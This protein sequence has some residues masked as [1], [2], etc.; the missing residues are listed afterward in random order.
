MSRRE[1]AAIEP[2]QQNTRVLKRIDLKVGATDRGEL[3]G[4]STTAAVIDV[5]TTGLDVECD[6]IIELAVR[7][8]RYDKAGQIVEIGRSWAWREDPEAPLPEEVTRLTG[9]TDDSLVGHRIDDEM[10]TSIIASADIVIAHNA[11]FDRPLLERRL[12]GL[13]ML[14]WACSCVEID[15]QRAGFES[16]SLGFLAMQAGWFFDAHRADGDVDAVIQLL[17]HED[18]SGVPLIYELDNSAHSDSHLIEAVGAGFDRKVA[19]RLRGYRWDPQGK[20]WWRE[21]FDRHL[22][23]EEF[24]LAREIYAAGKGSRGVGPRMTRRDATSRYR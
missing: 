23:A 17:Q 5:E 13:G 6:K 3:D 11:S 19:L 18:T 7:R 4:P 9:L 8:F 24:W 16:R 22:I 14:K 20:V 1:C 10:A 2:T 12:P 15:W 21:V